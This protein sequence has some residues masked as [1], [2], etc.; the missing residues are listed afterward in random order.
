MNEKEARAQGLHIID[1]PKIDN[2]IQRDK[3]V[4]LAYRR[5]I[6][7]SDISRVF[8]I[9]RKTVYRIIRRIASN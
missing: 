1:G 5:H 9:S 7:I 6:T 8:N 2:R 4:Y 3:V